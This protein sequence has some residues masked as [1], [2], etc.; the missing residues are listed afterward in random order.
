MPVTKQ[1]ICPRCTT[2]LAEASYRRFP[3]RLVLTSFDGFPAYPESVQPQLLRARARV[4]A[5][6]DEAREQVDYLE[7]NFVELVLDLRC[8]NG[9][10]TLRTLPQ[11]RRAVGRAAGQWVDLRD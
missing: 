3:P 7:K 1:L 10:S 9:H 2:V 4:E 11:L 5:G 6:D 8:R